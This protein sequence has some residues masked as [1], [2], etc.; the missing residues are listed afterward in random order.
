MVLTPLPVYIYGARK[1]PDKL[2]AD[3]LRQMK[4]PL[5][6]KSYSW[7]TFSQSCF[8]S[9]ILFCVIASFY[10]L[11]RGAGMPPKITHYAAILIFIFFF[12]LLQWM[13]QRNTLA[14]L[15][16]DQ[17]GRPKVKKT[18][19]SPPEE[20]EANR[21]KRMNREKRLFVHLFAVLQRQGRLM[22]FLQEDLSLYQDDQI[23]A[24]VRSIHE[25][26]RKTVARYLSPKPVMKQTEG[27][28]VEIAAGFDR[29]AVKLVGNVVGQPPFSGIL[30]H[31]GWQLHAIELPDL[32]DMENPKIIAP[33]E[34]EIQ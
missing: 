1:A 7:R 30:R 32:S 28:Q 4:D 16:A 33:A 26:C 8:F 9:I 25:N 10:W 27:E 15:V 18:A 11:L 29:N 24:S 5:L 13:F 22:D 14:K 23:G 31:R 19:A 2:I 17:S 3:R 6:I 12:S 21:D 34:V 20:T